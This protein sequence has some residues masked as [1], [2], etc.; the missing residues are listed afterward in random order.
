[1]LN[2]LRYAIRMLLKNP[3]FTIVAVLTLALGI[4]VNTAMFSV[5]N[6]LL[7]P[8]P[9]AAPEQIVVLAAQVKG[10]SF[11]FDHYLSYPGFLDFQKQADTFSDLFAY[12]MDLGGLSADGK[13]NQ[14]L[15]SYVSGNYFSALG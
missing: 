11:G 14:F 12:Q 10:D 15:F 5:V 4:G 3:G 1:M 13:A 7:R 8:L 9:V 6:G 2:D